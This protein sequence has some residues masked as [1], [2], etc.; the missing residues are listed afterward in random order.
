MYPV[1]LV[2]QPRSAVMDDRRSEKDTRVLTQ[3]TVDVLRAVLDQIPPLTFDLSPFPY[4][5]MIA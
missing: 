4:K 5:E 3:A 1:F 2:R